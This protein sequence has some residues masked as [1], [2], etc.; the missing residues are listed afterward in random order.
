MGAAA[1]TCLR[2]GV[3]AQSEKGEVDGIQMIT[4]VEDSRESGAGPL[5]FGPGAV[6]PLPIEKEL[7]AAAD[8]RAPGLSGGDEPED[9]PR[10]LRGRA[11]PLSLERWIIVR[12][13]RLAPSAVRVLAS[14]QPGGPSSH[15]G[16]R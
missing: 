12:G 3:D 7:D 13:E 1:A 16:V 2:P 4:K 14:P 8:R 15:R 10:G 9:N 11:R 6:R 5:L